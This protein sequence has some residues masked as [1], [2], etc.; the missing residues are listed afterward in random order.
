LWKIASYREN[1]ADL[2]VEF[3]P[4]NAGSFKFLPN[5]VQKILLKIKQQ[6]KWFEI[7]S[8]ILHGNSGIL[9]Y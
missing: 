1:G 4:E 6:K 7:I 3:G 9:Y 8:L 5:K 2:I